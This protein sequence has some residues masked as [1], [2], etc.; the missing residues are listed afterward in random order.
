MVNNQFM[1][2][3]ILKS[4]LPGMACAS[5]ELIGECCVRWSE[6]ENSLKLINTNIK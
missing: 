6:E 1:G 2:L 4:V 3:T 5:K